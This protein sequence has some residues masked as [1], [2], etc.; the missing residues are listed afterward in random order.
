M[1]LN[2][3]ISKNG[4]NSSILEDKIHEIRYKQKLKNNY[5]FLKTSGLLNKGFVYI[6]K[7]Y[8]IKKIKKMG[9][10]YITKIFDL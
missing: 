1:I 7:A 3:S 4:L 2:N 6:C 5:K 8:K 9:F 10:K